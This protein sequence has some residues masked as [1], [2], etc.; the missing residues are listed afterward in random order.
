M[1]GIPAGEWYCF[2]CVSKA[3]GHPHCIV[4]GQKQNK[5]VTCC[6]CNRHYHPDCVDPPVQRYVV[7][8]V[9]F[10]R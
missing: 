3:T 7:V 8:S 6:Q 4:C 9:Y 2:D 10:W 5:M 1:T